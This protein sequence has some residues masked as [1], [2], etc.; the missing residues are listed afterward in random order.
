MGYR[1]T[2]IPGWFCQ[3]IL[4][5]LI[6]LPVLADEVPVMVLE[7]TA[8]GGRDNGDFMVFDPALAWNRDQLTEWQETAKEGERP[9]MEEV[10][11]A[12]G[13][14]R[15]GPD[16]KFRLEI[17]ADRPRR[18]YFAIFNAK[19]PDG[20]TYGPVKTGNNFV[21]EPGKLNLRT[22]RGNYWVMTGG[23]YNDAIHSSWRTS[24]EYTQ[25]QAEYERFLTPAEDE[26]EE[27]R[28]RRV[29]KLNEASMR[30]TQIE[31]DGFAKVALNHD[32]PE[33]V[34]HAIQT[35]WLFGPWMGEAI[36]RLAEITPEDPWVIGRLAA[37]EAAAANAEQNRQLRVG[38][39]VL[40]FTA[41][42]LGGEEVT[43]SD[44]RADSRYLLVE[45]WASW[46]G[47]CRVEIPHMKQAYERFRDK[48]FEI[49][50]FTVDEEREDWEE[51]SAEED[52][53]WFDLGMGY[54][55][56]AAKAYNVLGVPNNYLVESSTGKIISKDLRQHKL[57]EKLEELLE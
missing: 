57:D 3:L 33:V 15:I 50:S 10:L 4:L 6:A 47:P 31:M 29:D 21:L 25:A 45:F 46:C 13:K 44:I 35:T 32:D 9:P 48:G 56:E 14:A 30:L 16:H 20:M 41:E 23:Y 27:A 5:T 52:L 53:P 26:T 18:V 40:D 38:E 28:R 11:G 54:E 42:T 51:A 55:A 24:E 17:P 22:I 12:I 1:K 39:S 37:M 43:L 7:G 36:Q 2:N 19:S 49:V 8:I 34:K